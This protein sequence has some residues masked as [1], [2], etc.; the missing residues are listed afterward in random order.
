MPNKIAKYLKESRNELKKVVW[1]DKRRLMRLT[2]VVIVVTFAVGVYL[3]AL[4]Y[5][6]NKLLGLIVR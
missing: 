4:D 2:A 1:P 3:G 5:L 6:L